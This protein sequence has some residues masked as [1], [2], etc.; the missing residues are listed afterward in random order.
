MSYSFTTTHFKHPLKW[1]LGGM[2][3]G[4]TRM[5]G[6]FEGFNQI[7][8][9]MFLRHIYTRYCCLLPEY[10]VRYFSYD[11]WTPGIIVAPRG[12]CGYW[13][14]QNHNSYNEIELTYLSNLPV[15]ALFQLWVNTFLSFIQFHCSSTDLCLLKAECWMRNSM[16]STRLL[17][18]N[19]V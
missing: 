3:T 9:S 19:G 8:K 12:H 13:S 16:H 7:F 18:K 17:W 11:L 15:V 14:R 4:A 10:F 2:G 1:H 6:R 5:L